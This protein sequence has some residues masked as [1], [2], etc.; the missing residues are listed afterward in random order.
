M[1][2]AVIDK[3]DGTMYAFLSNFYLHPI[4]WEG[5]RYPSTEHAYQAAKT[6]NPLIRAQ[7]AK[8]RSPGKVKRLGRKLL[9][10]PDW[11]AIK[12]D[13]MLRV[14]R[15]K[16]SDIDLGCNLLDTGHATLIEGNTWGDTFW[17]VCDGQ[18]FNMLGNVLM[19]IRSELRWKQALELTGRE[20][21]WEV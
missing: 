6:T 4:E 3:F 15:I 5:I 9:I 2:E 17:G 20:H 14:C 16:F 7:M 11:E 13:I 12:V 19:R 10:R 1:A 18:G 8:E 21:T